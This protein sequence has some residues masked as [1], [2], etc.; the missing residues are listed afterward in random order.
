M[1]SMNIASSLLSTF[2]IQDGER[3]T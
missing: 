1:N 2:L 3:H